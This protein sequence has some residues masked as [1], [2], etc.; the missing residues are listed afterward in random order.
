M[1]ACLPAPSCAQSPGK[2]VRTLRS[3]YYLAEVYVCCGSAG[4]P[5]LY[6]PTLVGKRPD[7]KALQAV[8]A[9]VWRLLETPA[10]DPA[11]A[12]ATFYLAAAAARNN[13]AARKQLAAQVGGSEGAAAGDADAGCDWCTALHRRNSSI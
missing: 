4:T 12:R 6:D 2:D 7:D 5:T 8:L 1:S 13:P 3:L 9:E 11:V 10:L